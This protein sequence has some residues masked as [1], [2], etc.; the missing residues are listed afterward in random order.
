VLLH[1]SGLFAFVT[2]VLDYVWPFFTSYVLFT[3]QLADMALVSTTNVTS[4]FLAQLP[5]PTAAGVL[6]GMAA[7]ADGGALY[8]LLAWWA[9]NSG[10]QQYNATGTGYVLLCWNATVMTGGGTAASAYVS[11]AVA[12][13]ASMGLAYMLPYEFVTVG[14]DAAGWDVLATADVF[15]SGVLDFTL[16]PAAPAAAATVSVAVVGG[17]AAAGAVALAAAVAATSWYLRKR[18]ARKPATLAGAAVAWGEA[19]GVESQALLP[20]R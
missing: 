11:E 6:V 12:T 10:D 1:P 4:P 9:D 3:V 18:A 7:S 16:A 13:T 17:A 8:G 20:V 19:G 15:P 2:A 5:A 14:M